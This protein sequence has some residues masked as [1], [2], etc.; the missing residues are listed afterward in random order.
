MTDRG[1]LLSE[2]KVGGDS[3]E[4]PDPIQD[5]RAASRAILATRSRSLGPPPEGAAAEIHL[6]RSGPHVRS[7][8]GTHQGLIADP[9]YGG[10]RGRPSRLTNDRAREIAVTHETTAIIAP[11]V[12]PR[13]P[14]HRGMSPCSGL[15]FPLPPTWATRCFLFWS[16]ESR[17]VESASS[18]ASGGPVSSVGSL[19]HRGT[20]P[21]GRGWS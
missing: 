15:L 13:Y 9:A 8:N 11:R 7:A 10:A 3:H 20:H 12:P 19:V 14:L 21:A 2:N 5:R 16:V 18:V 4:E 1:G 17:H 6:A